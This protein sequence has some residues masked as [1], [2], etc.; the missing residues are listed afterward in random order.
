[1][2][3]GNASHIWKGNTVSA[4]F[5]VGSCFEVLQTAQREKPEGCAGARFYVLVRS[6]GPYGQ[7]TKMLRAGADILAPVG[8]C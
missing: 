2:G 8:E 3:A 4:P 7:R 1:M 6:S 5:G